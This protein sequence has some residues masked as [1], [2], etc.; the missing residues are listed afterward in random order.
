MRHHAAQPK[1]SRRGTALVL[2]ILLSIVITAIVMCLALSATIQTNTTSALVKTDATF[3]AAEYAMQDSLWRYKTD[4]NYRALTGAPHAM[5]LTFGGQTYNCSTTC[6][7]SVGYPT[8]EWKFDE[9]SGTTTADNSGHGNTGTL[10][11]ATWNAS[12]RQGPSCLYFDGATSYVNCGNSNS[13]NLKGNVTMSAWIKL[14]NASYDQKIGGC[15]DGVAGGYK[16]YIYNSKVIFEIRAADNTSTRNK[17]Q[18]GGTVLAV[19][20]WYHVAGLYSETNHWIKTYVNGKEELS[21]RMTGLPANALATT[22]PQFVIGREPFANLYYFGGLMD[23]V[24]V[25]NSELSDATIQAMYN[26]AVEVHATATLAGSKTSATAVVTAGIPLPDPPT[27]PTL[28]VANALTIQ[29]S[30]INGDVQVNSDITG[31][32]LLSTINGNILY[33]GNYTPN[34]K[35]TQLNTSTNTLTHGSVSVPLV[36]YASVNGQ[37]QQTYNSNQTGTTFQFTNLGGNKVIV[38]NGNVTDPQFD[39][40]TG[41]FPSGGTLMINGKLILTANSTIGNSTNG[42]YVICT[43]DCDQNNTATLTLYGGL[44]VG[45]NWNRRDAHMTGPVVVRGS[46]NDAVGNPSSFDP[47]SIPWFDPRVIVYNGAAAMPM[48]YSNFHDD[49]N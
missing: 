20:T 40:T 45:G 15:E 31:A 44:Y 13:A 1:Y 4:N 26:T 34:L 18:P 29:N 35:I 24:R 43:G 12:A 14:T 10:N 28:T 2:A 7:D 21:R 17:N 27:L 6:T 46:I 33:A 47:G 19:N 11:G 25:Y 8:I 32:G 38:V 9:G 23:D 16:F 39:L 3:Y 37:A 49:K 42:V 41:V 22:T 48:L 36:S 30:T 5:T